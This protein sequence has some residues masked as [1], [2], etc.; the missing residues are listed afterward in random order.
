MHGL[1]LQMTSRR[2]ECCAAMEGARD[3]MK[4]VIALLPATEEAEKKEFETILSELEEVRK[5]T[6][7]F[8]FA[9]SYS[10][11][12]FILQ[13]VTQV[14]AD[15]F[16]DQKGAEDRAKAAVDAALEGDQEEEEEDEEDME[17]GKESAAEV[18]KRLIDDETPDVAAQA[19]PADDDEAN[20]RQKTSD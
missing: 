8:F 1:A 17:G 15:E 13:K 10:H 7:V 4:R 6:D 20:K 11:A 12:H 16:W 3:T 5:S 18:R 19:V 2:S 9:C 14:S